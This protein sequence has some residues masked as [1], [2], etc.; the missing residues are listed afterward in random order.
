MLPLIGP[1]L[2]AFVKLL[3]GIGNL[4]K[5]KLQNKQ[6]M[7]NEIV[8]PLFEEL[9]PVASNY[10]EIFRKARQIA[11]IGSQRKLH[12]AL[13]LILEEREVMSLA[14][15]KVREM[16]LQVSESINDEDVVIFANTV[17]K[18]FYSAAA[19]YGTT[20]T[21]MILRRIEY[22][23]QMGKIGKIEKREKE[24]I[25]ENIDEVLGELEQ[26]WKA[27]VQSYGKLKIHSVSPPKFVNKI[28]NKKTQSQ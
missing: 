7:F 26:S 20:R 4:E 25:M 23:K 6:T 12:E 19:T 24:I 3:E 8:K 10:K 28:Q 9:E 11:I 14:R 16:A 27:I 2:E 5:T 21:M 18:Y 17:N 13:A 22:E 1:A 15:I